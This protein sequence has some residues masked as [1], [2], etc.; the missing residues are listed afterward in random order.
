MDHLVGNHLA[1]GSANGIRGWC[2]T[3]G[4]LGLLSTGKLK[5]SCEAPESNRKMIGCS[6]K[7]T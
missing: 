5:K 7:K 6:Y 2:S 4:K 3:E 1:S